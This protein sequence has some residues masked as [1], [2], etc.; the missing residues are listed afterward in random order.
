M[1]GLVN[2]Q[3]DKVNGASAHNWRVSD[4]QEVNAGILI[5]RDDEHIYTLDTW[6][7][8]Y[9]FFLGILRGLDEKR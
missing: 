2:N 6:E 8:I 7:K 9:I 1:D 4:M 3:I 5:I